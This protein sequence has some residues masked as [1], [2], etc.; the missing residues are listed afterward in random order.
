[1][2]DITKEWRIFGGEFRAVDVN[3]GAL[4]N[5]YLLA[6]LASLAVHRNGE[7]IKN[8]FVTQV[9]FLFFQKILH[10]FLCRKITKSMF[11]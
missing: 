10:I 5:C 6:A 3:Q 1:M 9:L 7:Y 2:H 11:T 8:I 4:G